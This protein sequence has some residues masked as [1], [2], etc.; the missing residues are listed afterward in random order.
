MSGDATAPVTQAT[1]PGRA[2]RWLWVALI[3]SLAVNLLVV[4]AV[5]GGM[6]AMRHRV[7]SGVLLGPLGG[8][9][10]HMPSDRRAALK[11][12]LA[13]QRSGMASYLKTVRA[14]RRQA[15]D[16][17][18]AEPFDR[19][20]LEATLKGLYEAELAARVGTIPATVGIVEQLT[21]EER[22]ALQRRLS[23]AVRDEGPSSPAP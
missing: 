3:A 17:L 9:I 10:E 8:F 18:V 22:N 21:P 15:A 2:A 16:V 19:A 1:G 14:A 7:G 4:G 11:D 12:A 23:V 13:A 20:K 6:W 5:G